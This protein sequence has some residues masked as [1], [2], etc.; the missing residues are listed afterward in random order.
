MTPKL[1]TVEDASPGGCRTINLLPYIFPAGCNCAL[2]RRKPTDLLTH[3]YTVVM[4]SNN[5]HTGSGN[6]SSVYSN[7]NLELHRTSVIG[8][9]EAGICVD[10]PL[11]LS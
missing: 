7:L 5:M 11:P 3:V 2:L 6:N 9:V 10:D 8:P 4:L 1:D